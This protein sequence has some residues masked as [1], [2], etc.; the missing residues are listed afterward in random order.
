MVEREVVDGARVVVEVLVLVGLEDEVPGDWV[1][2]VIGGSSVTV[3]TKQ[4]DLLV[5][6]SGHVIPGFNLLRSS[7][8]SA[9]A[10]AKLWQLSPLLGV[11]ENSH[12]DLDFTTPGYIHLPVC[13]PERAYQSWDTSSSGYGANY[14]CDPPP[15]I[16]NCGDSTFEDQTSAASP[17]VEDCL[18]IIKNIQDDGKT[19]WTIQV[20]GKNQREIAKFGECRFGVEATEQTGNADFK[21][22]GQDVI[23][24]INDTVKKF[25]GSGRV[26][27]K[28]DMS[29]NGNIKGQAVKWGIY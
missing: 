28:G 5:S 4:Y 15:G 23:D 13:S 16:N 25:G 26:G 7:T 19:E 1:E 27:A 21:V 3:P 12:I 14:P 17:K 6:R 9:Q 24:I 8:E 11:I 10:S 22:G 29:C 2:V 18:Q 20:L